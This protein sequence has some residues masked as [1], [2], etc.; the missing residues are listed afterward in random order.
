MKIGV[1]IYALVANDYLDLNI[2]EVSDPL[3]PVLFGNIRTG[4][5][6]IGVRMIEIGIKIYALVLNG[7]DLKMIQIKLSNK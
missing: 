5:S 6:A 3:N 1:K 4:G 7:D 2:I